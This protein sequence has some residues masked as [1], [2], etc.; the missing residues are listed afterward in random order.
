VCAVVHNGKPHPMA[1]PASDPAR[2]RTHAPPPPA[3]EKSRGAQRVAVVSGAV[4]P[5]IV[6]ST[7]TWPA[8]RSKSRGA[9]G[10]TCGQTPAA[11]RHHPPR[12]RSPPR[13]EPAPSSRPQH[14]SWQHQPFK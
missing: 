8:R 14:D 9:N 4:G 5:P 10:A 11:P 12:R 2:W 6:D 1:R 7:S 3:S 13:A